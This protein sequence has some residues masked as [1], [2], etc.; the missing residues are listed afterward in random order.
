MTLPPQNTEIKNSYI[1]LL[2]A[3]KSPRRKSLLAQLG[4]QFT[5]SNSDIDESTRLNESPSDYVIRLAIAKAQYAFDQ[6]PENNKHNTLVL[7]SDTSV[8]IQGNILGKPRDEAH[9]LQMLT[10]LSDA[11]H[12]VLTSIA[13]VS[14]NSVHSELVTTHVLFKALSI[15]EIKQYWLSGEPQDKAGAYGIQGIGGQFIKSIEGSYSAVV[16]LPLYET[17]KLLLECGL[18][19]NLQKKYD[20]SLHER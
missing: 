18:A 4:Y 6:L 10:L 20:R 14:H 1:K 8:V 17:A 7:G 5:Q 19:N 3:S 9:C 15:D 2:L 13:V 12:E 11:K 16:G